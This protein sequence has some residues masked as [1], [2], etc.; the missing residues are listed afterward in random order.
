MYASKAQRIMK[1]SGLLYLGNSLAS[2]QARASQHKQETAPK[3]CVCS[4]CLIVRGEQKDIAMTLDGRGVWIDVN[5]CN[6]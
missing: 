3:P 6:T 5:S 1:Q 2:L 4:G